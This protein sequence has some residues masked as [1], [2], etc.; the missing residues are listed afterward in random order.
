MNLADL[1]Y[2]YYYYYGLVS[3]LFF[4]YVCRHVYLVNLASFWS[5]KQQTLQNVMLVGRGD[6]IDNHASDS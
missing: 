5:S 6:T 2:Y 3:N 1:Y 4:K